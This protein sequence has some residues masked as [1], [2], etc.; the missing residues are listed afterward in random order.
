MRSDLEHLE[1]I[2]SHLTELHECAVKMAKGLMAIGKKPLALLLLKRAF[3]HDVDKFTRKNFKYLRRGLD[4]TP[5]FDEARRNHAK[6]NRHHPEYH[7]SIHEMSD[8]DVAEMMC[9]WV[10]RSRACCGSVEEWINNEATK[11]YGFTKQDKIYDKMK[12]LLD[13]VVYKPFERKFKT[14]KGK[15]LKPAEMI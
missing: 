5:E 3:S 6:H 8:L 7:S 9:D 10:S 15:T 13:L 14:N 4:G 1:D 12:E 2:V 11:R